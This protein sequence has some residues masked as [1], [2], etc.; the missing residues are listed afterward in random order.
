MYSLGDKFKANIFA[1]LLLRARNETSPVYVGSKPIKLRRGQCV[2]GRF[3]FSKYFGLTDAESKR[4]Y[5][6]F[7]QIEKQDK[8]LSTRKGL[9]CTI[10]TI[11]NY[12]DWVRFDQTS[13]HAV[14]NQRTNNDQAM[15]TNKSVKKVKSE[16]NGKNNPKFDEFWDIYP[17]KKGKQKAKETYTR[18]TKARPELHGQIITGLRKQLPELKERAAQFVPYP[19]T[20]LSQER[21]NDEPDSNPKITSDMR[22]RGDPDKYSKI[23]PTIINS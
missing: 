6:K 2:F 14:A 13:G 9:N 10:V 11:K 4:L 8:L 1:N 12:D 19:A 18:L 5:R 22:V 21:W 7:K 3:E 16:K 17:R 20:W 23:K 15:T